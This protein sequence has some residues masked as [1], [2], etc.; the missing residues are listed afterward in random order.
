LK[1]LKKNE[2]KTRNHYF[3]D[4]KVNSVSRPDVRYLKY[5]KRWQLSRPDVKAGP[6]ILFLL[7]PPL[8]VKND[9]ATVIFGN[10]QW[11]DS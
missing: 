10:P 8:M 6:N 9:P 5:F 11:I 4:F 2:E 3:R 7:Q 1:C